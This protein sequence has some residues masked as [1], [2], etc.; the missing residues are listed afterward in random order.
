FFSIREDGVPQPRRKLAKRASEGARARSSVGR[1]AR[2]LSA[3]RR[4]VRG[5]RRLPK[6]TPRRVQQLLSEVWTQHLAVF[7]LEPVEMGEEMFQQDRLRTLR[8]RPPRVAH[9]LE[10]ADKSAS[11][12]FIRCGYEE[13]GSVDH[14]YVAARRG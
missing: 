9:L 14:R 4:V 10:R 3:R 12:A 7:R 6:M 5:W 13:V 11:R 1:Y 8:K 2:S